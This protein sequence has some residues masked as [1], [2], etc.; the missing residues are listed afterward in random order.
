[1]QISRSKCYYSQRITQLHLLLRNSFTSSSS[2]LHHCSSNFV[3]SPSSS[4]SILPKSKSTIS[5]FLHSSPPPTMFYT[6]A[7]RLGAFRFFSSKPGFK[8]DSGFAKKVLDKPTAALTSTFS[9][10]RQAMVLQIEA[11]FKRNQ[12]FMF[13]AAGVILCALLWRMLFGIANTFVALSE[14]MAKY[15]FLALSSAIVAFTVSSFLSFN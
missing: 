11:F 2:P 9:R 15:G 3:S 1:M 5:S 13:G 7:G 14:G 6:T 12:L 8:V 4:F 10:Y